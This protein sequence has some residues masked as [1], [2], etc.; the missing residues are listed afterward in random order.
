MQKVDVFAKREM[1]DAA[2]FLHDQARRRNPTE[3][4]S[5]ARMNL[6]AELLLQNR[7]AHSPWEKQAQKHQNLFHHFAPKLR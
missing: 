3:A 6:I 4:D 5:A 1:I 7:T 2:A